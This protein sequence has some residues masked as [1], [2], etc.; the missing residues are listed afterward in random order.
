MTTIMPPINDVFEIIAIFK[1]AVKLS[2]KVSDKN[3]R[4]NQIKKRWVWSGRYNEN[5]M[6]CGKH[7]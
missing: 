1:D 7:K 5:G 4:E 2:F 6:G 3:G